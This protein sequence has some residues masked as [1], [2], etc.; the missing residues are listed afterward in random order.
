MKKMLKTLVFAAVA[1]VAAGCGSKPQIPENTLAA[2]YL[3][4]GKAVCNLKDVAEAAIDEIPDKEMRKQAEEQFKQ[5]V[6]AHMKDFLAADP[7]WAVLTVTGEKDSK[8]GSAV[9]PELALVVKCDYDKK[10]PSMDM[11]VK[12]L[13]QNSMP[14]KSDTLEECEVLVSG[15]SMLPGMGYVAFVDGKFVILCG[16]ETLLRKYVDL[17][18]NGKGETSDDFDDL[19]DLDSDTVLRVQSASGETAAEIAG[20]KKMIEDFGINA[21]DEDLADMLLDF[22]QATIDVNLSDDVIG[23]KLSLATG[24]RSL[25]KL[26][27]GVFNVVAFAARVGAATGRVT[28][29]ELSRQLRRVLPLPLDL[30]GAADEVADLMREAVTADRS[31]DVATLEIA[32]DTDDLLEAVV[33]AACK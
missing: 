32:I 15:G 7:D 12:Q 10:L 22:E 6:E 5:L 29:K 19:D 4:I 25:A 16:S 24:D 18:K 31:G 14:G 33:P 8:L 13:I 11:T 3:D 23:A 20:V 2:A 26:F 9:N 1:A 17:Y 27:E 28:G 30:A 21:K